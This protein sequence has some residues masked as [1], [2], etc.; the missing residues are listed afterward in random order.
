MKRIAL[1]AAALFV[2]L[3]GASAG[4]VV[5]FKPASIYGKSAQDAASASAH[6]VP[7]YSESASEEEQARKHTLRLVEQ[8]GA[9]QDRI[10]R[11]DRGVLADQ[12]RLL[13]DI[14][15]EIRDFTEEEKRD[16]VNVR[17]SLL[18]VLSGG[19]AQ[20]LRPLIE[21]DSL[22]EADRRLATGIMSFAEGLQK[23]AREELEDIDPRSLDVSLVG[24]FALARASLY[25]DNDRAKAIGLLDEARLAAP[26]TAID[27]A[28]ARREIPLLLDA[29]DTQRAMTLTTSYVREFGRSIYA[30]KL[31]RDFSQAV[32][33]HP[34]F[35]GESI[36]NLL[37]A[38][39][40]ASEGDASS[41]LFVDLAGE[42]LLQGR[43]KL[44]KAAAVKVL[45]TQEASPENLEK[46]KLYAAAADAPSDA[47]GSAL[48]ALDQITAD[49]LSEEDT[50]MRDAADFIAKSVV[51]SGA[52]P[53]A[54]TANATGKAQSSPKP[55]GSSAIKAEIALTRADKI[56]KEADSIIS[57]SKE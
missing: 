35:D 29:G 16:Y 45:A 15:R 1:I 50:E 41:G 43:L 2:V 34:G 13:N 32:A 27:E 12:Q 38:S 17:T 37:A 11:G 25:L 6:G 40:P 44:A 20:V 51:N 21:L 33:K 28:S 7:S 49:R 54:D 23:K 9:V 42:A 14:A 46:A 30:W 55:Q 47:A 18:Y 22:G 19:D 53:S 8:L 10:I 52:Q 56:L 24:P 39:F 36:V 48:K 3:A 31:F 57:G 5:Y 26:H 4:F